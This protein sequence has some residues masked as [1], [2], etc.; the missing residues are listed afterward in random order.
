MKI[1]LL[2]EYSGVHTDLAIALK[3]R[4]YHVIAASNGNAYRDF[5]RDFD[6]GVKGRN[7]FTRYI[8]IL[9]RYYS[10]IRLMQREKFD[11][12]Q[13]IN[14]GIFPRQIER[15][16]Y[17]YLF[18]VKAKKFLLACGD[19]DVI[20][21]AYREG[22]FRY[23]VF[24]WQLKHDMAGQKVYWDDPALRRLSKKLR[25]HVHA[26]IPL[27]IEYKMAYDRI[28]PKLPFIPLSI[29][30]QKLNFDIRNKN[31][32]EIIIFHGW[33]KGREGAKGTFM[34]REAL[35]RIEEKFGNRV[36]VVYS[37]SLPFAQYKDLLA[38]ATIVV[39][40]PNGYCPSMNA[41]YAMF[42]GCTT[43]SGNEPEY[44]DIM[45]INGAPV[46]NILPD[47]D[48]IYKKVEDLVLNPDNIKKIGMEAHQFVK[49]HHSVHLTVDKYLSV[50]ENY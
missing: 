8:R 28:F 37:E 31:Y 42:F 1:L 35:S 18:R 16:V 45:G 48:D 24:T 14:P 32:D 44:L 27:C 11:V 23:Y 9:Y 49:D 40:Q 29:D 41:L 21:D 20:W 12:I 22:I 39:D 7:K 43:L 30:T 50:W 47:A 33:A 34:I 10:L 38:R 15:I 26:V 17:K 5:P 2:G 3:K 6:L 46:V 13:L 36:K 4:G 25:E 19:D